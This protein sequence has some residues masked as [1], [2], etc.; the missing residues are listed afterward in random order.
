MDLMIRQQQTLALVK[1]RGY[2]SIDE[3]AQHFAVTPQTVRRI[4]I[5][6]PMPDYYVVIM[7]ALR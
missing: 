4:S 2:V 5:N 7:V 3:I 6:W 1:A